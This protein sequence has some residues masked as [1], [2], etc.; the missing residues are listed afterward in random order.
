MWGSIAGAAGRLPCRGPAVPKLGSMAGFRHSAS[1]PSSTR[2]GGWFPPSSLGEC[3]GACT[4][5]SRKRRGKRNTG[6]GA[7]VRPRM[8]LGSVCLVR[9]G[10]RGAAYQPRP[11][12]PS[13][14]A[15]PRSAAEPSSSGSAVYRVA[16][17]GEA[18]NSPG[19]RALLLFFLKKPRFGQDLWCSHLPHRPTR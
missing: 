5:P 14:Q 16:S 8:G 7:S 3:S 19:P 17:V 9:R 2:G 12:S 1:R 4:P 18:H 15:P 13:T 10:G 6:G 11:P